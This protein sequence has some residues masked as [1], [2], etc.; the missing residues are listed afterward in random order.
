VPR[1]D[2][3][4]ALSRAIGDDSFKDLDEDPATWAVTS[5]PEVR[6]AEYR[7]GNVLVLACDGL[8][9]VCD[10]A[11]V[12]KHVAAGAAAGAEPEQ[13]A[14]QLAEEALKRGSD[15][16]VTVVVAKL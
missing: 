14:R 4:L 6:S 11:W 1:I 5:V 15:D 10:N 7:P 2:G 13:L 16:N 12:A 3:K 9:D 8:F